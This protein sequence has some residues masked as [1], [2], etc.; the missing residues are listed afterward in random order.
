[1]S[2]SERGGIAVKVYTLL[3]VV[4]VLSALLAGMSDGGFMSA[5]MGMSDGGF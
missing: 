1:M 3:I 5:P 2:G 4:I